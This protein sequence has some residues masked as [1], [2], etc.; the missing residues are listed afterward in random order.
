MHGDA[1]SNDWL[2][3][4]ADYNVINPEAARRTDFKTPLRN[5]HKFDPI[6]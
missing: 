1:I 5:I 2:F 3:T 6:L 4:I